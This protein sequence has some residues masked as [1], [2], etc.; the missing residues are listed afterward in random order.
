MALFPAA[1]NI[2]DRTMHSLWIEQ[3]AA[4]CHCPALHFKQTWIPMRLLML[5]WKIKR[6][7]GCFLCVV[8]SFDQTEQLFASLLS[9]HFWWS[10]RISPDTDPNDWNYIHL[11]MNLS[12]WDNGQT[13]EP[14]KLHLPV[15]TSKRR[16]LTFSH[17]WAL[18]AVFTS[19]PWGPVLAGHKLCHSF[20]KP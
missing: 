4:F 13:H 19:L 16:H 2:E 3:Q 18:W 17:S 9:W 7:I 15:K 1:V 10:D 14:A 6:E 5:S 11:S 8:L 12:R 20:L